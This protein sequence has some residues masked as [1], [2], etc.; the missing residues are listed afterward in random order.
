MLVKIM[1]VA[2]D[3]HENKE[4]IESLRATFN[5]ELP[6]DINVSLIGAYRINHAVKTIHH[7]DIVIGSDTCKEH[8]SYAVTGEEVVDY[9]SREL[10]DVH[11][12]KYIA[13]ETAKTQPDVVTSAIEEIAKTMTG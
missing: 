1:I 3:F 9:D 11:G 10:A 4:F 12:K 6:E 13:M 5:R 7:A 2:S 8:A